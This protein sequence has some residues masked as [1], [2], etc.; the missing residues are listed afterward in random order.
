MWS[1]REEY[2]RPV[3]PTASQSDDRSTPHE[4]HSAVVAS[5]LRRY[6]DNGSAGFL[7]WPVVIG[8]PTPI[9]TMERACDADPSALGE[10]QKLMAWEKEGVV[11][12][13]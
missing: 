9:W 2:A 10:L 12:S 6:P 1:G 11:F 8:S 13:M 3:R 7:T 5:L 4:L